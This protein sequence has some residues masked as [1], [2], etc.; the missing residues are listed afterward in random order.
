[1]TPLY[2]EVVLANLI[3]YQLEREFIGIFV[4]SLEQYVTGESWVSRMTYAQS[5][6]LL[7]M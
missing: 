2:G 6:V 3:I 7:L 5:V 4:I 1:M